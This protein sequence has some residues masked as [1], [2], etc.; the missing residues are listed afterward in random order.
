MQER[1][2]S[3][4]AGED[5]VENRSELSGKR[6]NRRASVGAV[7]LMLVICVVLPRGAG[8]AGKATKEQQQSDVRKMTRD[9]LARL[10]KVQ[11]SAKSAVEKAAG[12]AV[13]SNFGMKILVMGGGSGKGLATNNSTKKETFMKMLE[14]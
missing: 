5:F 9:V 1:G 7:T 3:V 13:F 10:Y 12:Y 8:A 2:E 14:V 4:I 11:P 6:A